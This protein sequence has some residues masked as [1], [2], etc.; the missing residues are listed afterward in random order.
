MCG[1]QV[2][3]I[4]IRYEAHRVLRRSTLNKQLNRLGA[5][6]AWALVFICSFLTCSKISEIKC[7]QNYLGKKNHSLHY[8]LK[9]SFSTYHNWIRKWLCLLQ[10]LMIIWNRW[11][12]WFWYYSFLVK[13][14]T[15]NFVPLINSYLNFAITHN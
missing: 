2:L 7:L 6:R 12:L 5:D 14:L 9:S 8:F 11:L 15:Y 10:L 1:E 13:T 3:P 4:L